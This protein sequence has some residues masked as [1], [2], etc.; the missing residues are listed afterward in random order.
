MQIWVAFALTVAGVLVLVLVGLLVWA[1]RA[2]LGAAAARAEL[3]QIRGDAKL[4]PRRLHALA[5]D[6][7]VPRSVRWTIL[8][9]ALYLASPIDLIPDFLPVVGYLDDVLIVLLVL[10]HIRRR[11]PDTVWTTYFPPRQAADRSP[12]LNA[13]ARQLGN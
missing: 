1:Q 2:G 3:R 13:S 4:S 9:L 5:R 11:I 6:S 12:N 10:R 7:G 8:G